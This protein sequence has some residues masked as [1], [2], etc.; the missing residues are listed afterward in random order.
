[1]DT[2]THG[3][4]GALIGKAFFASQSPL[5]FDT[6]G[7][8]RESQAG[9]VAVF[10][11]TF[12]SIFPDID[13]FA[14]RILRNDLAVIEWHRGIT[15]SLV[16]LPFFA[17]ALGG[18]MR[19]YARRR[20]W[21]APS[22]AVL[23]GI[24]AASIASHILLDLITSFGTMIWSPLRNT[25]LQWDM[26]FIVD[27]TLTATALV[28]QI[29]AWVH[30]DP[31][32]SAS[33]AWRM[34]LLFVAST[35][36]VVSLTRAVGFPPSSWGIIAVILLLSL[37]F[38]S[39]LWRRWGSQ[40]SQ[41]SWCRAGIAAVA[42]YLGICAAAHHV[43]LGR[44]EKFARAQALRVQELG[45]LPLPPSA[46]HWDGLI[47]TPDGVFEAQFNVLK[48][49]MPTFRFI[50][51]NAPNSYLE[52]ARQIPAV[53]K[54]LWFARFPVFRFTHQGDRAFI[55]MSDLRF[56]GRRSNSSPFTFVVTFDSS[57][58]VI[59]QGWAKD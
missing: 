58:R 17:L 4:A 44:V 43:A 13:V 47:R 14:G 5:R 59:E 26:V 55:Q 2:I 10:A 20:G 18:V 48:N 24:C 1:M 19:L 35:I 39:P 12:S 42:L 41:P 57:G 50:A 32:Q 7:E 3:I 53:Q 25:R 40:F 31:A 46:A 36:G 49:D 45:A 37:L 52:A 28:P 22:W 23:T 27:F 8:R 30:R 15:H 34:W 6:S 56:F 33:R 38:L 29:L 54:Y 51:D 21:N 11:A 9:R 16:C